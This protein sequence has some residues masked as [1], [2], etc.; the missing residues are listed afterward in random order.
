MRGC[1]S[2]CSIPPISL[3][4]ER[5][6]NKLAFVAM[7]GLSASAVCMGAAAAIGGSDFNGGMDFSMFGDRPRCERVA[8][9]TATS[10]DLDWDGSDHIGLSVPGRANYTPGS[11]DKVHVTGDPQAIAHL[12]VRDGRIEMDC[13]GWHGSSDAF[14]ITLPGQEFKKFSVSGSGKL[15]LQ[16]LDQMNIRINISGSGSVKADGK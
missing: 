8:D 6:M 3:C 11:D 13:H 14:T 5:A 15:A 16:K 9:A 12:R 7:I 10:R 4:E 1:T 2:A